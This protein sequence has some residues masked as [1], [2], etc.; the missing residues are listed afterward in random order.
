[1][2]KLLYGAAAGL[3]CATLAQA[4]SI[5]VAMVGSSTITIAQLEKTMKTS[6]ITLSATETTIALDK[7]I[8]DEIIRQEAKSQKIVVDPKQ[9]DQ[10]VDI[11]K[12]RF[13]DAA[14]F[15]DAL[16]KE[17][18][19]LDDIK[20]RGQIAFQKVQLTAKCVVPKVGITQQ[21]FERFCEDYAAKVQARHILVTTEEEAANLLKQIR[22][23]AKIA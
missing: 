16:S 4:Q 5:P 20:E 23:G 9:I 21:M 7:L 15:N 18:L 8:E 3:M 22:E 2:R 19:T 12:K 1:M 14:G 11:V 17:G 6:D 13:S 10:L